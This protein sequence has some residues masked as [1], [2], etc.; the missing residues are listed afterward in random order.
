MWHLGIVIVGFFVLRVVLWIDGL[1]FQDRLIGQLQLIDEPL[2]RDDPFRAFTSLHIQPPLWNFLVG[3]VRAWSPF[4]DAITFQVLWTAASLA[5]ATMLWKILTGSGARSWQATVATVLVASSPIVIQ[6]E[7]MLRYETPVTLLVTGSVYA[8]MRF[9][10]MPSP[11]RLC[12]FGGVVLAGVLTRSLLQ[13]LWMVG[14]L[15]LALVLVRRRGSVTSRHV[16]VALVPIV[17]VAG[18]LVFLHARFGTVGYS[19][20][21]GENL[22]RIAVTTLP[23]GQLRRLQA[24][25]TLSESASIKP[26]SPYSVYAESLGPCRSD[27]RD[28]ALSDV[29]KSTGE[30][31]LNALCFVPVY[32]QAMRDSVAAIR[33][34]PGNYVGAVGQAAIAF[35]GRA[36]I[37][38]PPDTTAFRIL[39][40]AYTPLFLPLHVGYRFGGDDPQPVAGF[41]R[42]G[43]SRFPLLLTAAVAIVF[44]LGRAAVSTVRLLRKEL[45]SGD[46]DLLRLWIGFTVLSVTV[47]GIGFDFYENARFREAL[48]PL[49]FGPLFVAVGELA[50]RG[51]V[52]LKQRFGGG[53]VVF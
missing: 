48:D 5:T 31:N 27:S 53:T 7:S 3:S 6:N 21:L 29:T 17:L 42:A 44:A 33:A 8:F 36:G 45:E 1:R 51:G 49:L 46:S 13:P 34:D 10:A 39:N 38:V 15:V 37:D 30:P 2:L 52:H 16:L 18:D 26:Y 12:V 43:M 35:A 4:P 32:R 19:S 47:V 11:G 24:D 41:L 25:G 9:V 14:G 23:A 22:E 50:R 20:Y 40:D 28:P